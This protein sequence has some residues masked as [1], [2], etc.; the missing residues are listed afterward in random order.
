MINVT[1]AIIRNEDNEVLTVQRGAG[2]SNP[3]MW[4]FPGG[5]I[6]EGESA[7]ECLLRRSGRNF[8]WKLSSVKGWLL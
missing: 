7:E 4:E 5:K 1:C 3:L 8:R 6:K 2:S